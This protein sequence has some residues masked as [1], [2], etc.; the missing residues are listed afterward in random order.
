MYTSAS[1]QAKSRSSYRFLASPQ[2][3]CL[4]L[5]GSGKDFEETWKL[6]KLWEIC[7]ISMFILVRVFDG[8]VRAYKRNLYLSRVENSHL[9][10]HCQL[11]RV[12]PGALE[13]WRK[14]ENRFSRLGMCCLRPSLYDLDSDMELALGNNL[15]QI[16]SSAAR[17][18]GGTQFCDEQQ[19][20]SLDHRPASIPCRQTSYPIAS[21]RSSNCIKS[22]IKKTRSSCPRCPVTVYSYEVSKALRMYV[23]SPCFCDP[24]P[25]SSITEK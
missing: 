13:C 16:D 8:V 23:P 21:H 18:M 25:R 17:G 11:A 7:K 15:Q 24:H 12:W 5:R 4:D 14:M 9:E 3:R 1:K 22:T 19:L 6:A 2:F 10:Y 20:W